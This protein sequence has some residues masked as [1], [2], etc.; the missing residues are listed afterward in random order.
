MSICRGETI[1]NMTENIEANILNDSQLTPDHS[2]YFKM[3]LCNAY[4]ENPK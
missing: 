3:K 4:V 2:E 1:I